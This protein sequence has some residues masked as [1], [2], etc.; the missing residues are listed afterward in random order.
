MSLPAEG[1]RAKL[2]PQTPDQLI[3]L[4]SRRPQP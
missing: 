3:A 4:N 1:D 2:A